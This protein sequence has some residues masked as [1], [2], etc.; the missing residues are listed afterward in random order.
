MK[1]NEPTS[2]RFEAHVEP[3][4]EYYASIYGLKNLVSAGVLFFARASEEERKS[5]ILESK[6]IPSEITGAV[7]EILAVLESARQ[8]HKSRPRKA[9]ASK[10]G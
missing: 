1:K 2:V 10:T 4:K 5:F 3:I 6:D 7:D 8:K 9:S